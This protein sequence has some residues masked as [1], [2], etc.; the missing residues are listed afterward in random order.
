[1]EFEKLYTHFNGMS[2]EL[3]NQFERA[4]LEQQATQ[5]AQV[6]ALQSQI[7]PHFLNNTLEIINWEARM[8]DNEQVSAM[9]EALSTMLDA[10]LDRDGRTQ[11]PLREEMGYVD[12]YLYIIRERLG[13]GFHV[14]KEIDQVI[15]DQTVPRLIL[16]P[17][18]E[19]AVEHDI[20]ARHGGNLWVRAFRRGERMV[21]EV[22]HDGVMDE[23]DRERIRA[24]LSDGGELESRV[25][26]RNVHQRLKLIYG[27]DASLEVGE[28]GN[29]AILARIDFPAG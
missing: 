23:E 28:T 27:D 29:G 4:R 25:G 17:I 9:I 16:Q 2:L 5:R 26:L 11:I 15:L 19:N 24:L 20:T 1:M 6:K 10:A 22:E 7:N 21:L 3:Q 13:D 18:V 14:Y 8:A 12:A